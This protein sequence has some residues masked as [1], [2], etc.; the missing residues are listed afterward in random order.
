M[1]KTDLENKLL[2]CAFCPTICR[3]MCPADEA[4]GYETAAPSGMGRTGYLLLKDIIEWNKENT[5]SLYYCVGCERCVTMCPFADFNLADYIRDAR[6][7]AIEKNALPDAPRK[8]LTYM[9]ENFNPY[10]EKIESP[11]VE[12]NGKV[13]YYPG[14]TAQL[15]QPE[16]IKAT[17][18]VLERLSIDYSIIK[19]AC[20]GRPALNIGDTET[21][22]T[23]ARRT[24]EKISEREYE[25]IVTGCPT[26]AE[27]LTKYYKKYGLKEYNV[28]PISV[29]INSRL[30]KS[31]NMNKMGKVVYHDPCSLGRRLGYFE[32]P[33]ELLAKVGFEVIEPFHSREKATCCGN[34]GWALS[35]RKIT[36]IRKIELAE[37]GVA[38]VTSCPT[39]KKNLSNG[40]QKVRDII[41][42]VAEVLQQK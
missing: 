27:T 13:L 41:E 14:C 29:F 9:K 20:C 3:P 26:C 6:R 2:T 36:E 5:S 40:S 31:P 10:G 35:S 42:L 7:Y 11:L 1:E 23:I 4:L 24:M 15:R 32:E 22:L 25:L 33:R 37:A 21:F 8:V 28:V 18:T 34:G 16:I 17:I 30:S 38:I 39:C 19:N 12:G